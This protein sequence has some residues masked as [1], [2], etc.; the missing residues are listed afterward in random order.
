[1][2]TKRA[3][4]AL[5]GAALITAMLTGAAAPAASPTAAG[6]TPSWKLVATPAPPG[7][8]TY[9]TGAAVVSAKD[10]WFPGWEVP[11]AGSGLEGGPWDLHWDGRSLRVAAAVPQT[12]F[13]T[14]NATMASFDSAADGWVV[15]YSWLPGGGVYNM[16]YAARWHAGRWT[17]TPLAISPDPASEAATPY[18]AAVA[19]LS[20][21]DA[22]IVGN[23]G[24]GGALI[25]HWDGSIWSIVPN[26]AS[27]K[28]GALVSITA[29]SAT[30][31]WA[32]GWQQNAAGRVV[33]LAERW[34]GTSWSIVSVAAGTSPSGFN[35]ISADG[36]DNVWAVGDQAESGSSNLASAFVE[37]WDGTAWSVVTGL[38][39]LGNSTLVAAYAAGPGDLWTIVQTP[40]PAGALFPYLFEFVHWD[41]SSWTTVALPGPQA[42]GLQ[43]VAQSLAGTGPDDIWA[44]GY[45]VDDGT[46]TWYP[47]IA[48]LS[49]G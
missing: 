23:F 37:H 5:A 34:D 39:D 42:S 35:A 9:M 7:D 46:G 17:I 41:G 2:H 22:W 45:R 12:P 36:P 38:P 18:P 24:G 43:Y 47:V 49:C 8:Y 25:E 32:A 44:A 20:P 31:I 4:A 40:A 6:C 15:G 11:V 30:D 29:V 16:P 1:M 13:Q 28:L 27:G 10:A 33:P 21:S 19:S 26:P 48:H 14:R 3:V